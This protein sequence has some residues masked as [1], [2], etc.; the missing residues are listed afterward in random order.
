MRSE[1]GKGEVR[2]EEGGRSERGGDFLIRCG[3]H[4][5]MNVDCSLVMKTI[6]NPFRFLAEAFNVAVS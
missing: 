6:S 2:E 1:G 5:T 3:S 4:P